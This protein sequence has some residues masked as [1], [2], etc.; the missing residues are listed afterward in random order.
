MKS[1]VMTVGEAL[2]DYARN[3]FPKPGAKTAAVA[4]KPLAE[5]TKVGTES[6]QR[7]LVTNKLPQGLQMVRLMHFLENMGYTIKELHQIVPAVY[8]AGQ[9]VSFE[10]LT[11]EELI[12]V[13]HYPNKHGVFRILSGDV[14]PTPDRIAAI[15]K[16]METHAQDL[17]VAKQL[18]SERVGFIPK[19]TTSTKPPTDVPVP[20]LDTPDL[21]LG[22]SHL[23]SVPS[24][25]LADEH[26]TMV[27]AVADLVR[28]MLPLVELVLSD[29]FTKEDRKELRELSGRDGVFRL[30]NALNKLC[31][32][33]AREQID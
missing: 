28:A 16:L 20:P 13:W 14:K 8:N 17:Q 32:E 33:K 4:K 29:K 3:N 31:S 24:F 15:E 19:S 7:W 26:R 25:R 12:L 23:K 6:V 22:T 21:V 10:L 11:L 2:A 5:F 18:W 30:S 27:T 1:I 9:L